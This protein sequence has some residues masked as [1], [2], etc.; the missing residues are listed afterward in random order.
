[1]FVVGPFRQG[2]SLDID[3]PTL[4]FPDSIR[5]YF[6]VTSTLDSWG[7]LKLL[8]EGCFK[9]AFAVVS[10]NLGFQECL[11]LFIVF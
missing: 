7:Y 10:H 1:M 3:R 8:S 5:I 2:N 6:V 9:L 11:C 4:L